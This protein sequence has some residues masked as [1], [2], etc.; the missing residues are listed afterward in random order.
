MKL[1][2][3]IP[4]LISGFAAPLLFK[5][6]ES[7]LEAGRIGGALFVATAFWGFFLT[8][9]FAMPVWTRIYFAI[10]IV[11]QLGFWT[12]RFSNL[13]PLR[14]SYWLGFSGASWHHVLTGIYLYGAILLLVNLRRRPVA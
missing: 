7:P 2:W 14:E 9:K 5:H 6:I 10:A 11:L 3:A 4:Y 13:V 1:L 12:W 8:K